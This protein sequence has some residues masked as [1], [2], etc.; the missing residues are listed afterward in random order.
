M[1]EISE[2]STKHEKRKAKAPQLR[3]CGVKEIEIPV[4]LIWKV[5][6]LQKETMVALLDSS[7]HMCFMS[8]KKARALHMHL[9]ELP[10]GM[11][12]PVMNANGTENKASPMK[13]STHTIVEY[14]GHR[15]LIQF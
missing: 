15:E 14:K 13:Y 12:V 8:E 2:T 1:T 4:T 11:Q 6:P 9:E 5:Q 10:K 3:A 7:A